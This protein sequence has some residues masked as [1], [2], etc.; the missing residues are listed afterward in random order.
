VIVASWVFYVDALFAIKPAGW[1]S[2]GIALP[3]PA[4]SRHREPRQMVIDG[5]ERL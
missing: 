4:G 5:R 1:G 2:W 3:R